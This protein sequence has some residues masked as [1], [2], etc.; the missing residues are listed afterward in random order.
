MPGYQL[1]LP[2]KAMIRSRE[3]EYGE[4]ES[5]LTSTQ[6]IMWNSSSTQSSPCHPFPPSIFSLQCLKCLAGSRHSF[7]S[8]SARIAGAG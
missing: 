7:C 8:Q 1:N 3:L 2:I 5:R 4:I 6:C